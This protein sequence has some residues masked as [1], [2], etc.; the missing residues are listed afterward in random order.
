MSKYIRNII[1]KLIIRAIDKAVCKDCGDG[2][3][4]LFISIKDLKAIANELLR[5]EYPGC[6]EL[7]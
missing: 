7:K 3:E 6:E 1:L 2:T 5:E 4:R